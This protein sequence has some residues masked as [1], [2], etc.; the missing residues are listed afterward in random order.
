[1]SKSKNSICR[2]KRIKQIKRSK[3]TMEETDHMPH[4]RLGKELVF[5]NIYFFNKSP[6]PI[7]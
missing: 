7:K 2:D 6:F 3:D 5:M 1:M 4:E